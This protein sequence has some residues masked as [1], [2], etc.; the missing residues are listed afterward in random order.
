MVFFD[1]LVRPETRTGDT[2]R[3]LKLR[4]IQ[5]TWTNRV[6]LAQ[7]YLRYIDIDAQSSLNEEEKVL[8]AWWMARKVSSALADSM[9]H[10]KTED[11]IAVM[12][13]DVPKAIEDMAEPIRFTHL[14]A[15]TDKPQ[16]SHRLCTLYGSDLPTCATLALLMPHQTT[17]DPGEGQCFRGMTQP[18][19]AL[20][21]EIRNAIIQKL[22]GQLP[23]GLGQLPSEEHGKIQLLWNTPL[24]VS[25]L[26]FLRE[27]Y[28]DN[29]EYLGQEKMTA[30]GIA[31]DISNPGFLDAELPLLPKRIQDKEGPLATIALASLYFFL[32][33]RGKMPDSARVFEDNPMLARHMSRLDEPFGWR[34]LLT[35]S[36]ILSQLQAWGDFK[37]A[38]IIAS[39]FRHVDY[40]GMSDSSTMQVVWGAISVVLLGVEYTLLRPIFDMGGSDKKVRDALG[41]VKAWLSYAFPQLPGSHREAAR[42]ILSALEDIPVPMKSDEAP[43][44]E[45]GR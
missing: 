11:Q 18:T 10:Y 17:K 26:A 23:Q 29:I 22:I 41:H 16:S 34:C 28:A 3:D 32:C 30:I 13:E 45:D 24:C 31:E 1:V 36:T 8:A 2:E 33:T 39:L 7:H 21:G 4:S 44:V 19:K 42:R 12:E 25:V 37:W 38:G 9:Q 40:S 27:Y 6:S 5:A 15:K 20:S 14:F 43:G 35:L